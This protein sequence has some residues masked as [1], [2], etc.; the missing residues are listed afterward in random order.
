[1]IM[2]ITN[3]T[4]TEV[5]VGIITLGAIDYSGDVDYFKITAPVG[6]EYY[7]TTTGEIDTYGSLLDSKGIE[8]YQMM[9]AMRI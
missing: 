3:N 8:L 2:E 6:G 5:K 9:I 4:A 7:I 1:M